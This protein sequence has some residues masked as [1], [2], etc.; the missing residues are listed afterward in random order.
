MLLS[1]TPMLC[2]PGWPHTTEFIFLSQCLQKLAPQASKPQV[3]YCHYSKSSLCPASSQRLSSHPC[4]ARHCPHSQQVYPKLEKKQAGPW[5]QML[6]I[7]A[8]GRKRQ[9][10]PCEFEVIQTY[11]VRPCLERKK[12]EE[13][14]S[15]ST[16][17]LKVGAIFF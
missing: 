9:V 17:F 12:K 5:W 16:T 3:L 7:P 2:C 14:I 6:L 1:Y 15:S 13:R 4:L 11:I 10:D 8:L